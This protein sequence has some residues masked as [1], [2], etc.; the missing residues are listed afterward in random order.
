MSKGFCEPAACRRAITV[1]GIKEKA[2][3]FITTNVTISSLASFPPSERASMAFIPKG[4]AA[5]P[6]PSI[7]ALIFAASAERAAG[8]Q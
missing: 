2:D 8:L 5:F 3:V 4:V 6:M 7:F 1:D